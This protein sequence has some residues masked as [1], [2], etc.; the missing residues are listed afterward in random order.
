MSAMPENPVTHNLVDALLSDL[1][2]ATLLIQGSLILIAAL[3]GWVITRQLQRRLPEGFV[4]TWQAD[5][6]QHFL[7]PLITLLGVLVARPIVAAWHSTHLLN[8]AVPLLLSMFSIQLCFFFLRSLFKPGAGLRA[9]E[10]SVSWVIW[11]LVALH[12]AG[13]LDRFVAGLDAIGFNVGKQHISLYTGMLGLVTVVVT[14]IGALS[15]GRLFENRLH[16]MDRLQPNLRVALSKIVR[17]LLIV[18]AVLVALPLVGIDI[19]VLS[20]FGGALG[21]GLGLGLQ[22]IASNYVSGFTLLLENSV[23]IGDMVEVGGRYGQVTQIATR[24]TVLRDLDGTET[25]LPNET[26]ITAPV[27]NHSLTDKDNRVFLPVQ[28]AYGTDLARARELM[29]AAARGHAKVLESPRPVVF[30]KSFG[31]SGIDLELAVWINTPDE[32]ER[33]LRS[34]LNWAIW[35]AFQEAGIEIPFPQRV[36]RLARE[37]SET[38]A[39]L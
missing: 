32:G 20:V 37:D 25:V 27:I 28:V 6:W 19:T 14:L 23:R 26:M 36:V 17:S 4:A 34:D 10:R 18:L 24:Y 16:A 5:E 31:E 15:L 29:L 13:Y 22:K 11:G 21:V 39:P 7:I 8:L 33:L 3:L 12:I 30:L 9:I 35:E 2:N 1:S 38:R